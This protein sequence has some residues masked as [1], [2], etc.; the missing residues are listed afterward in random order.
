MSHNIVIRARNF[1]KNPLLERKQF[2]VDVF[3][4]GESGVT[5]QRITT[6]LAKK[7]KVAE[8]LIVLYGFST[9]FG[10]GR[11][12]GFCSIYDSKDSIMRFESKVALRRK[13]LIPKKAAGTGRRLKK[14]Q[15]NKAKKVRGI[16]KVAAA[17][18]TDKKKK[19]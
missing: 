12:Q 5:K 2:V 16:A 7:F 6:E 9:K 19:K 1:L 14:E 18:S 3:H 10:G 11:S 4:H 8:D 15:K 17:K 13:Q